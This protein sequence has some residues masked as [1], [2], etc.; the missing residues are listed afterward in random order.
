MATIF[1]SVEGVPGKRTNGKPRLLLRGQRRK[2]C[3]K[4]LRM[5]KTLE[6]QEFYEARRATQNRY[7]PFL[8]LGAATS[9]FSKAHAELKKRLEEA[10]AT[11]V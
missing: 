5:L 7:D 1:L 11:K 8:V 4:V 10:L 2:I 3:V 6:N 9:K